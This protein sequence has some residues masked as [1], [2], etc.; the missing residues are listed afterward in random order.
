MFRDEFLLNNEVGRDY[1]SL[2]YDNSSEIARLLLKNPSLRAQ[3]KEVVADLL[4][5]IDSLLTNGQMAMSLGTLEKVKSLLEH[6]E[7]KASP[8]LKTAIRK[9]RKDISRG[10]VFKKLGISVNE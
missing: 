6:F 3:T 10:E 4:P 7:S 2:L 5:G 1:T 9:V 8:R